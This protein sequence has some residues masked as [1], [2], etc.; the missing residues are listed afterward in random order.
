MIESIFFD[1]FFKL[2]QLIYS[3]FFMPPIYIEGTIRAEM[4][5]LHF[6]GAIGPQ[7]PDAAI[8]FVG[9]IEF[10]QVCARQFGQCQRVKLDIYIT[11]FLGQ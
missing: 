11:I 4:K 5:D 2:I 8:K 6:G 3:R 1:R 10:T 9:P 7:I